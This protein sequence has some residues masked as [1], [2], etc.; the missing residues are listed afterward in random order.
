MHYQYSYP[1][2]KFVQ[3]INRRVFDRRWM[4]ADLTNLW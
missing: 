4:C 3:V 2:G 1:Q